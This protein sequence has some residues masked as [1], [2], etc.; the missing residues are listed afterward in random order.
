[1]ISIALCSF[2]LQVKHNAYI[3][4]H[5]EE[6]QH[7]FTQL[8]KNQV[9]TLLFW[10]YKGTSLVIPKTFLKRKKIASWRLC[11]RTGLTKTK[12]HYAGKREYETVRIAR[13]NR[14]GMD[15]EGRAAQWKVDREEQEEAEWARG[16]DMLGVPLATSGVSADRLIWYKTKGCFWL[17]T[18]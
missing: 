3:N 5:T 17:D 11:P 7:W 12:K 13:Q 6:K 10:L 16:C 9:Q 8:V 15:Y 14:D 18:V 4:T 2:T 1:M